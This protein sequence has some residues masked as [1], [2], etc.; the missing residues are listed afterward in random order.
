M[1]IGFL[2]KLTGMVFCK[3]DGKQQN[4]KQ[5]QLYSGDN[6]IVF[7]DLFHVGA[8]DFNNPRIFGFLL[9]T[10]PIFRLR[11]SPAQKYQLLC[12]GD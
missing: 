3:K 10:K 11:F 4:D 9:S 8:L 6:K 2:D 1:L 12:H 5:N 7:N